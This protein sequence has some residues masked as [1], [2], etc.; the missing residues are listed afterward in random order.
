VK[1]RRILALG[2]LALMGGFPACGRKGD[3]ELPPPEAAD[4]ETPRGEAPA[5]AEQGD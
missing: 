1:R 3:L 2:M 5:A 4:A